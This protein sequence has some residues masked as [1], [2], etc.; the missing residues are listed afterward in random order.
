VSKPNPDRSPAPIQRPA[1]AAWKKPVDEINAL[2]RRA[3]GGDASTLPE[4]RKLLDCPEGVTALGGDLA[5]GAEELLLVMFC[6]KNLCSREAITRKMA[7]LRAELCGPNAP[8]VERLL[9]ERAVAC[10]LHL[11][12]VENVY[13]GKESMSLP[14]AQHYQKCIDRA[15]KRYLSALKALADVRKL[16]ITLQLNIARKQVNVAGGAVVAPA[17]AS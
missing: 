1:A 6:G 4:L 7:D 11:Y 9:A 3:Q 12:Q 17:N 10:W 16:G 15:H 14:L 13:A 2:V 5:R 8:P